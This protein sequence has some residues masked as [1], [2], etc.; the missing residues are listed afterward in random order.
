MYESI[1]LAEFLFPV[2]PGTTSPP[3]RLFPSEMLE[4]EEQDEKVVEASK[5]SARSTELK[6][7]RDY[8]MSQIYQLLE[9]RYPDIAGSAQNVQSQ[10]RRQNAPSRNRWSRGA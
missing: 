7:I 9:K 8:K 3:V 10:A 2:F 1:D 5:V 4:G 6:K